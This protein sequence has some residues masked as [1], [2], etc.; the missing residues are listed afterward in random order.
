MTSFQKDFIDLKNQ[1][2]DLEDKNDLQNNSNVNVFD[3]GT[4]YV[5]EKARLKDLID[6]KV[7]LYQTLIKSFQTN[8]TSKNTDFLTTYQQYSTANQSLVNGIKDKMA[9]V[10]TVL[11]AFS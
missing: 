3:P 8:Y 6:A 4:T 9:K 5:S 7:T 1:I 10:Q 2:S 11:D